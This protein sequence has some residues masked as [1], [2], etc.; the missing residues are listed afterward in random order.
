M[1][2]KAIGIIV[3]LSMILTACAPAATST[4]AGPTT[5]APTTEKPT[6]APVTSKPVEKPQYGGTLN[7]VLIT[8]IASWDYGLTFC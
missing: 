2:K 7:L 5:A 4:T 6:T 8:D 1:K 3:L